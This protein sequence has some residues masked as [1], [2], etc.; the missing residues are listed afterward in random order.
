MNSA[1]AHP[2]TAE[3]LRQR[4]RLVAA[5][6][7]VAAVGLV[8]FVAAVIAVV[9]DRGPHWLERLAAFAAVVGLAALVVAVGAVV[10]LRH[11]RSILGAHPWRTERAAVRRYAGT[12]SQA[13]VIRLLGADTSSPHEAPSPDDVYQYR[14]EIV[15]RLR[16]LPD[17]SDDLDLLCAGPDESG[18]MV[19]SP[20]VGDRVRL[21][22]KATFMR[23]SLSDEFRR[24]PR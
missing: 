5:L 15:S 21:A 16:A 1:D 23:G 17:E 13:T 12:R 2:A 8:V 4:A 14:V 9:A 7:V 24:L 6:A 3:A 10:N 22:R 20:P 11:L 18:R 19:V